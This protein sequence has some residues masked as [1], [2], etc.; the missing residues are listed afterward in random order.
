MPA[1]GDVLL[2]ADA[3]PAAG[4]VLVLATPADQ[5]QTVEVGDGVEAVFVAGSAALVIRNLTAASYDR[6]MAGAPEYANRALDLLTISGGQRTALA[7]IETAHIAW[8][9][10]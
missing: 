2:Y 1:F 4:A 10:A 3:G 9:V 7:S 6:V 8:W 5:A